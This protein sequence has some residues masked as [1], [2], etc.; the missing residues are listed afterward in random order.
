MYTEE[1]IRQVQQSLVGRGVKY[2]IGAYVDIHGIPKA[3]V[4]PIA[5]LP[6]IITSRASPMRSA[7]GSRSRGCSLRPRAW[8]WA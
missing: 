1:K 6:Q 3:K 7:L 5:H 2:C 8:D 4:V